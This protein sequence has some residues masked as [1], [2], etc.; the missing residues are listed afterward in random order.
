MLEKIK[1]KWSNRC[2]NRFGLLRYLVV[3]KIDGGIIVIWFGYLF[4]INRF[5]S[6]VFI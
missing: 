5:M 4:L 1:F 6:D 3:K 2:S